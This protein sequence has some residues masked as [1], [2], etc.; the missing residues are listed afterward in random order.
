[1][2]DFSFSEFDFGP[3]KFRGFPAKVK[4]IVDADTFELL[5]DT[6]FGT[7]M[8]LEDERSVRLNHIDAP[9]K[10]TQE[11]LDA[12]NFVENILNSNDYQVVVNSDG[13]LGTGYYGRWLMTIWTEEGRLDHL[14]IENGYYKK[15]WNSVDEKALPEKSVDL[16]SSD[17]YLLEALPRVGKIT[18]ERIVDNRPY[19]GLSEGYK[20]F[21]DKVNG[22]GFNTLMDMKPYLVH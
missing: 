22:V 18:A 17:K 7:R 3:Q 11:G 4:T 21:L 19:D 10:S 1:M 20:D 12:I 8:L 9:E 2:S 16:N 13:K 6:G 15:D 14:L 5:V